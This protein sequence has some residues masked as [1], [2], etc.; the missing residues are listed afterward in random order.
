MLLFVIGLP[1][2][3]MEDD[4]YDGIFLPKGSLV[5]RLALFIRAWYS[6]DCMSDICK[7]LVCLNQIYTLVGGDRLMGTCQVDP[8]GRKTLPGSPRVQS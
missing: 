5:R 3:L 8:Q 2:R 7:R 1:H 6:S 4:V